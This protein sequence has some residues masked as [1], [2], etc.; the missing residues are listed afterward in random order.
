MQAELTSKSVAPCNAV[1]VHKKSLPGRKP[2]RAPVEPRLNVSALRV[3]GDWAAENET[4]YRFLE[5]VSAKLGTKELRGT[6]VEHCRMVEVTFDR[7]IVDAAMFSDC[8][9]EGCS[10]ANVHARK[11]SLL[12]VVAIDCRLTGIDWAAGA[13]REVR[14]SR[15]KMNLASFRHQKLHHVLFEDCNLRD[16]DF[17][18]ADLRGARFERCDLSN[19]QFSNAS[20]YGARFR[21]CT[22]DQVRGVESLRGAAIG[23]KDLISLSPAMAS[24]IGIRVDES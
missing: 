18:A 11:S 7:C 2:D 20:L 12:R 5:V 24:A 3:A 22:L 4:T 17:Q 9:F 14:F 19:V 16:S 21:D 10:L 23:E 6:H 8:I 1:E 13:V 15:C